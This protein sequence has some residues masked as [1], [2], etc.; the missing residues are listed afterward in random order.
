MLTL[1]SPNNLQTVIQLSG[2]AIRDFLSHADAGQFKGEAKAAI[3]SFQTNRADF[4]DEKLVAYGAD[5]AKAIDHPVRIEVRGATE[6]GAA[7][8][9]AKGIWGPKRAEIAAQ[10]AQECKELG[11]GMY[12]KLGGSSSIEFNVGGVDKSL[13]IHFLQRAF[14]DVLKEMDYKPGVHIDSR[15]SKTVIAADGD[16]TIYDA[17]R[18][19]YLPTLAESPVRDVLLAYLQAGGIFMLVSGNDLNRTY[20]RL[21]DALPKEFYCRVLVSANGGAELVFVN[22]KGQAVP[23]SGYRNQALDLTQ[24]KTHQHVLDIVYIGD[25]GSME[26]NDYP[27]FKAVGFNHSVLVAPEFLAEYDPGLESG[28]VGGLL[29]GTKKYM[30]YFLRGR[31][32]DAG[33]NQG[34]CGGACCGDL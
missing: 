1:I 33:Q 12:L 21:V 23:V 9:V 8:M 26:G 11:F 10:I 16:G 34:S 20:R 31:M 19:G 2:Q 17:P 25:D 24:D 14:E 5:T 22:S 30:E 28:Y 7:Q 15:T 13:P 27:A 29:Q 6:E 3:S 4:S 18:L 32:D